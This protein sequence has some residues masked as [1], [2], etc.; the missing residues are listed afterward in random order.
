[1]S[2]WACVYSV[3][4]RKHGITATINYQPLHHYDTDYIYF[5]IAFKN[6]GKR[7]RKL[8][9]NGNKQKFLETIT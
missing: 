9:E 2:M 4:E 5:I 7:E 8:L 6:N 3:T 1:M